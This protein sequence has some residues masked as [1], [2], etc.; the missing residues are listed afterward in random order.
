MIRETNY[1]EV[2]DAQEHFR[3]IMESMAGPGSIYKL[4]AEI[5]TA[6]GFSKASA[7]IGFALL[8]SNTS[9]YQNYAG[10]LDQYFILNTAAKP[11]QPDEAD[12]LF[13]KESET[14]AELIESAKEGELEYPER[15]AF[16]IIEVKEI[17]NESIANGL[18]L[19]LKGPG[20]KNEKSIYVSGLKKGIL[21]AIQEKNM[22]YPLGVDTILTDTSGN[23]VCIP[24]SNQFT[25]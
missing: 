20:V 24:R 3:V 19:C 25:F 11:T 13:L 4:E 9:F 15:S 18:E 16:L 1:D 7:L 12:F 6:K 17:S 10:E 5:D 23:I 8:D 14:N 22:E 2:F 21:K